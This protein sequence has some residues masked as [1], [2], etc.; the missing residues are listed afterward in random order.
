MAA[1][2]RVQDRPIGAQVQFGRRPSWVE[3]ASSADR[4]EGDY[5]PDEMRVNSAGLGRLWTAEPTIP[6]RGGYFMAQDENVAAKRAAAISSMVSALQRGEP[7]H[8]FVGLVGYYIEGIPYSASGLSVDLS[9]TPGL[10]Q[11]D[12]GFACTAFFPPNLVQPKT[13][14]ANGTIKKTFED[15]VMELVP[16]RLDV[17]LT[18]IWSVAEFTGGTQADLFTDED[19]L[20][21]RRTAFMIETQRF[22]E[23]SHGWPR[24]P[25]GD[26]TTMRVCSS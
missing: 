17:K 8:Y 15:K 24:K 26:S 13:V 1:I 5:T 19:T 9:A 16:V 3:D 18:D 20:I 22:L 21:S 7:R 6:M 25:Q 23:R 12:T 2:L 14:K 10:Y 11:T 4:S